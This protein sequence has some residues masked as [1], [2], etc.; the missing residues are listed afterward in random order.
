M[1]DK[2]IRIWLALVDTPERGEVGYEEAFTFA[3]S[4]CSVDTAVIYDVDDGQ[5][6]GSYSRVIALVWCSGQ[7]TA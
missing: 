7:S 4:T 5:R 3:R 1:T 2:D 6:N